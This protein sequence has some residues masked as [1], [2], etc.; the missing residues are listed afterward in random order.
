MMEDRLAQKD[1]PIPKWIKIILKENI[2]L[3]KI[4]EILKKKN[5]KTSFRKK[6]D[7]INYINLLCWPWRMDWRKEQNTVIKSYFKKNS[8]D[9]VVQAIFGGGKTTMMLAI[10]YILCLYKRKNITKIFICAFNIGIR[11]ELKKKTR[12]IGKIKISTYDSLIYQCCK[13]LGY[14]DLKQ[15]NFDSKRRFVRENLN[16]L[17][18]DNDIKYVFIDET[19]DLEKQCYFILK[20]RFPKAKFMFVGDV[21]QSIQKEPRESLLW[22][23]INNEKN[24]MIFKMIDTPRVPVPILDEIKYA[25]LQYYPEFA[26]TIKL[27]K[28]SSLFKT[29]KNI[30]WVSFS[31]YRFVY[32]E[33]NEK[34]QNIEQ[35]DTMIL[36]FS[37]AI[38]VRGSLGDIARFRK[39]LQKQGYLLNPNHKRMLDDRLFLTTANSSKGLERNHV[40]CILTFPLELAF[41]NFSN[42][43]VMNLI[44]VA[45]SRCKEDIIFYVP[46]YMDRFS[47]VLNCFQNCPRPTT[48]F[49]PKLKTKHDIKKDCNTYNY[50]PTNIIEMLQKEHSVTEI[51]RQS[52]LSFETRHI[53]MRYARNDAN[54]EIQGSSIQ[55]I[56]TEEECA[57]TGLI[58]ESL[59]LSLWT[60][61][62]PDIHFNDIQHHNVFADHVIKIKQ[63]TQY[64]LKFKNKYKIIT[65]ERVR[66]QGSFLY[67]QLH[68]FVY[69][70]IWINVDIDKHKIIFERW[71]SLLPNLRKIPFPNENIKTQ[72]NITMP[73]L[74]GIMDA[75]YIPTEA[76]MEIFE[77]KASKS[78][79]WKENTLLQSLI[80]GVMNGKSLFTVHLIN[81][82][83]KNISTYKVFLK[84]DLMYLRS[85]IIQDIMN[86]NMNCFLAKNIHVHRNIENPLLPCISIS[87]N[88]FIDGR[89]D[90]LTQKWIEFS[91]C[92]F[93]SMTKTRMT[94]ISTNDEII[95]ILTKYRDVYKM[96]CFYISPFLNIK[97]MP[98]EFE[99]KFFP[100]FSDNFDGEE[101]DFYAKKFIKDTKCKLDWSRSY[102]TLAF[103]I[104]SI[105]QS[106]SLLFK[107]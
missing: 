87:K 54:W 28:S 37:S 86:W 75:V 34:L 16:I 46:N 44:T 74:N 43:L 58:F 31:S 73:F 20:H 104:C 101:W 39:F 22:Y 93:V 69:Q 50:D 68:L 18:A 82:F 56:N 40:I 13:E 48:E 63:K 76:P 95:S 66:F 47:K 17:N 90:E 6:E 55:N 5:L 36:T 67:A 77:I 98:D 89:Y 7:I 10:I 27:W 65:D 103:I 61:K 14:E 11:N 29:I 24:N 62:F 32:N 45:L 83:S 88:I 79:D 9:V 78:V 4:K 106:S 102:Q 51:L 23:L 96:N 71:L 57:L 92:E 8:D 60:H 1:M 85:L 26:E 72:V 49:I 25:L 35:K 91:I 15:L 64:Y 100:I 12:K 97:H 107:V 70:K 94:I 81:V 21:F 30:K 2:N 84:K 19:Q 42:D 53:L 59:L 99:Y 3:K 52:I 41:A 38:T 33:I 105:I 80:Y